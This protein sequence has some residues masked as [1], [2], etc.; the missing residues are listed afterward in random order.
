MLLIAS[1]GA[2]MI[3]PVKASD[4]TVVIP[5]VVA[6]AEWST[7]ILIKPRTAGAE[8]VSLVFRYSHGAPWTGLIID[9]PTDKNIRVPDGHILFDLRNGSP[10]VLKIKDRYTGDRFIFSGWAEVTGEDL[11]GGGFDVVSYLEFRDT[12]KTSI[13]AAPLRLNAELVIWRDTTIVILNPKDTTTNVY[14][15]LRCY[16]SDGTLF[17]TDSKVISRLRPKEQRIFLAQDFFERTIND[18]E[19]CS[20]DLHGEGDG[21]GVDGGGGGREFSITSIGQSGGSLVSNPVF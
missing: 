18:S 21:G 20:V 10:L 13:N 17:A 7:T 11:G 1:L 15:F 3:L 2:A 5:A 4:R 16:K 12:S 9:T 8:S 6:G 19:V 14:T